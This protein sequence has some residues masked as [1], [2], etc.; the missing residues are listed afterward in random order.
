LKGLRS[1]SYF[2]K[3]K[4]SLFGAT[5]VVTVFFASWFISC[6]KDNDKGN[7]DDNKQPAGSITHGSQLT[8]AMVGP[9]AISISSLTTV[10]GGTFNGTALNAWG[11]LARIVG[12]GGETIDGFTFP[13]GTVV[14][15]AANI[16]SEITVNSGWLVLR[17]CKGSM[18]LNHPTGNGGGGAA[19][20]CEL[21][22]FNTVGRKWGRQPAAGIVH[23]CYFPHSGLENVYSDN[24]TITECWITPDPAA[25]GSGDH[26]DGIQTWG[27]QYYLNF[28]R[29]HMEFN[30]P[31]TAEGGFSGLVGMYS[32]GDQNGFTGYDHITVNNNY[33]ILAGYGI[34][35]HAPLGVPVTN[36]VVTGN[37]WKWSPAAEDKDYTNAVY[38][39]RNQAIPNYK[40]NGNSWVDNRWADG[41]YANQYILPNNRTSA[42]EY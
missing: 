18:L 14:L 6:K 8:T 32:D 13:A 17:G 31:H 3:K 2:M 12:A 4:R 7:N 33:F 15:Q 23:R 37:R 26:I 9:S 22:A 10:P 5:A 21:T 1:K 11:S 28:S 29:N 35:L 42:T 39:N 38:S 40:A 25:P 30:P 36:M 19:L 34:A 24:I 27:G 20:Y 16:T 41:P